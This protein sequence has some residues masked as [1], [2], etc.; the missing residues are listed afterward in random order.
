VASNRTTGD[1][2]SG[3][4]DNTIRIFSRS[5]D[6][7]ADETTLKE[8]DEL[9][10]SSQIPKQALGGG[11]RSDYPGPEFLQ[12]KSGTKDGQTQVVKEKDGRAYAY[13]WSIQGNT[14]VKVG[15]V[16]DSAGNAQKVSYNG[17]D[18][19]YVFDVDIKE[20]EPPLKLPYNANQS[21]WQA[22]YDFLAA[23]ELPQSYLEQVA[24]FITQNA[25]GAALEPQPSGPEPWGS[26]AR[27]RPESQPRP[28]PTPAPVRKVLP[29]KDYLSISTGNHNM[30]LKKMKEFSSQ[31]HA[32]AHPAAFLPEEEAAIEA[33]VKEITKVRLRPE[34]IPA[35]GLA[36]EAVL[37][38]ATAWPT[39]KRLPCLD[40]L[41]VLTAVSPDPVRHFGTSKDGNLVARLIS[42]GAFDSGEN[43]QPEN[44]V[45]LAVRTL[46]N[47]FSTAEGKTLADEEFEHEMD[48]VAV[49]ATS[50][51]K[52][53]CIALTTLYVNYAVLLTIESPGEDNGD[54]PSTVDR[55]ITLLDA[56]SK[57]LMSS[58]DPEALYRALVATGTVL[59][60][61]KDYADVARETMDV[62]K[63]VERALKV[64]VQERIKEVVQEIKGNF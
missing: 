44:N 22:S 9:V 58:P 30:I 42:A 3:A 62:E 46:A 19:D 16:V 26:E 21:P 45:M 56:L 4:S 18:Y 32:E 13:Q 12:Q 20:G 39:E 2:A 33:A 23:N 54:G 49:H 25:Q 28:P 5:P 34:P 59:T 47:L 36:L 52:N 41:R 17:K 27:Y 61:G 57:V 35:P 60:L 10:Q 40:F 55:V 11:S 15:E 29:Q 8:Y 7:L 64:G 51:N 63:A 43:G 37:R 31:L 1:I 14:W 38:G 50:S 53:L 48:A 6:R 24:N